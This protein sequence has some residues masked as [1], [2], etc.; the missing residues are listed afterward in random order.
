ML[1]YGLIVFGL[2]A[3]VRSQSISQYY[4]QCLLVSMAGIGMTS[5]PQICTNISSATVTSTVTFT[6]F[7]STSENAVTEETSWVTY[8]TSD[9]S[10]QVSSIITMV[11]TTTTDYSTTTTALIGPITKRA[12]IITS[13]IEPLIKREAVTSAPNAY[14]FPAQISLLVASSELLPVLSEYEFSLKTEDPVSSGDFIYTTAIPQF[15]S[16]VM[17]NSTLTSEIGTMMGEIYSHIETNTQ[18]A[19]AIDYFCSCLPTPTQTIYFTTTSLSEET[20]HDVT[21]TT[22]IATTIEISTTIQTSTTRTIA[23]TTTDAVATIDCY[24]MVIDPEFSSFDAWMVSSGGDTIQ[25]DLDPPGSVFSTAAVIYNS[26]D[27]VVTFSQ[28]ISTFITGNSYTFEFYVYANS[29]DV[30]VTYNFFVDDNVLQSVSKN[31]WVKYSATYVAI[32]PTFQ[33]EISLHFQDY[34]TT[35]VF[36]S[37]VTVICNT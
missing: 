31:R 24:N 25:T 22:T 23:S 9:I 27:T 11:T 1:G 29:N 36:L 3:F 13:S 12:A 5:M 6:S 21:E 14:N 34:Y 4:D 33:I 32:S 17:S 15:L 18:F 2:C 20:I 35:T 37:G 8:T 28:D 19:M 30:K 26:E 10:V 7:A 16:S